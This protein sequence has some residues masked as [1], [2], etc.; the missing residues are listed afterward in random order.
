MRDV[1]R[2]RLR[3]CIP[4]VLQHDTRRNKMC[5][6]THGPFTKLFH[7]ATQACNDSCHG[8]GAAAAVKVII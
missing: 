1:L 4:D 3:L 5:N 2:E 6:I 7:L 8:A